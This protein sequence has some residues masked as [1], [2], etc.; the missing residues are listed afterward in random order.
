MDFQQLFAVS[1]IRWALSASLGRVA[2]AKKVGHCGVSPSALSRRCL[3]ERCR[4]FVGL[5][6]PNVSQNRSVH[7]CFVELHRAIPAL[8]LSAAALA[9]TAEPSAIA[10]RRLWG[11]S[12]TS[13]QM[14]S[15]ARLCFLLRFV[16]PGRLRSVSHTLAAELQRKGTIS[17]FL[18]QLRHPKRNEQSGA[19]QK[20][21]EK[22]KKRCVCAR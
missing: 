17:H 9:P 21:I 19:K 4:L 16:T 8:P 7:C 14:E 1:F 20:K 15:N 2:F 11:L 3:H 12:R 13:V 6:A 18:L 5:C 22:G 10:E